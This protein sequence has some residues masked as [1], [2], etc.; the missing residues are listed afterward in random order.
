MDSIE[1]SS[2]LIRFKS[3]TPHSAGSLEYIQKILKK[4]K[5]ECHLLEFNNSKNL[6]FN[7]SMIEKTYS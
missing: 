4:R 3:I 1:I 7:N 6:K 2:K 5:F